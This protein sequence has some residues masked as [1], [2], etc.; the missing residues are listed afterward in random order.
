MKIL[1]ILFIT[2]TLLFS[3]P[4]ESPEL[5]EAS[6]LTASVVKLFK[7][8]KFAEAL[9][10]AKRAL[11]IR[12]GLLP[13]TDQRVFTSMAYLGD[14]YI[15][16]RYYDDARKT[17]ERLLQVQEERF[18][19]TDV[20]LAFALDRLGLLYSREGK[21]SKA[22][23][24]YQ[25]ALTVREKAFGPEHVQVADSVFA[26]GQFYRRRREYDRALVNYKRALTTFGRLTGAETPEFERA[27]M[28][29][30]CLAYETQSANVFNELESIQKQFSP[31]MPPPQPEQVLN[32][33]A[34]VMAKPD[35][36]TEARRLN[37]SGTVV[38]HVEIDEAGK[39][40]GARDV[41]QGLPYLSESA[42]AAALKSRF[43][44]TRVSGVPVKSK[45]VLRYNFVN[46]GS[47]WRMNPTLP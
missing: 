37:L 2:T 1:A 15:A 46:E 23:D 28:G 39:V 44:P 24:M 4:Q 11:Q 40:T 5:K 25:R 12:E 22:E 7:E 14:L 30:T 17:F 27:R 34:E 29:F 6:D 31:T 3:H 13:R 21:I 26:L 42:V 45:G 47:I 33:K 32:A 43:S 36:P 8:Q 41:C 38:V 18:G 35:Y 20:N 10:L 16:T 9:P 19:P